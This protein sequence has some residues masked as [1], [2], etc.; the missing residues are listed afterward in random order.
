MVVP[1]IDVALVR[2]LLRAQHPDL[3]EL[4]I[5]HVDAGWDN[6]TFRL[7]DQLAVRLPRRDAAIDLI[8][9]EQ[10]WMPRL[11]PT[12]PLPIPSPLR[13]GRPTPQFPAPWSVVPWFDG[14]TAL[15][16]PFDE[17]AGGGAIGRFLGVLHSPAASDSPRNPFRGVPLAHRTTRLRDHA[18]TLAANVDRRAVMRTWEAVMAAAPWPGPPLWIHGDLHPGNL[19]V[20][21]R[22]IAAVL[23]FGDLAGGDPATDF[24]IAWMLPPAASVAMLRAADNGWRTIDAD[25]MRRARGWALAIGLALLA[26]PL[27]DTL[28]RAM[29]MRTVSAALAGEG[30]L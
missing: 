4:P 2:A 13:M 11:A 22:Q 9:H 15:R 17:A 25:L 5:R 12:L 18:E 28:M 8:A 7:G 1:P 24:A 26:S 14:D 3:A 10:R 16:V 20:R 30:V 21:E 27:S 19:L 23:D 29:A 6:D